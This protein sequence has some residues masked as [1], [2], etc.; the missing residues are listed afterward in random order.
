MSC[1]PFLSSFVDRDMMMLFRGGGVGHVQLREKLAAYRRDAE[2]TRR[3]ALEKDHAVPDFPVSEETEGVDDAEVE[4]SD[5][6]DSEDAIRRTEREEDDIEAYFSEPDFED[7]L[8][9]E[10]RNALHGSD[11]EEEDEPVEDELLD[12]AGFAAP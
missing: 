7:E 3:L 8:D 9:R 5:L 1:L 11:D 2:S 6:N 10:W 12:D 4:G